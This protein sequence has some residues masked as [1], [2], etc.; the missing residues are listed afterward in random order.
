MIFDEEKPVRIFLAL[1]VPTHVA[2]TINPAARNF[3]YATERMLPAEKW[4]LT[5]AWLGETHNP[6]Q[7][8]SRL[9]KPMLQPFTPAIRLTYLG[10]GRKRD[11]LWAYADKSSVLLVIREELIK[12]LKKM[13]FPMPEETIK[14]EYV[15]HIHVGNFYQTVRGIGMADI[16]LTTS[17]SV[18]EAVLLASVPTLKGTNYQLLCQIPLV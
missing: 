9:R 5:L 11:Q 2:E 12:R 16:P 15:P 10:R 13:R 7:Y 1:P 4:H 6:K 3:D 14:E 17:F 8:I 18:K